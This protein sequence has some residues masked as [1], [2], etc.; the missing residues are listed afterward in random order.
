MPSR[1]RTITFDSHDPLSQA[2]F[3]GEVMGRPVGHDEEEAWVD[4]T[5]DQD[6]EV[7]DLLF[8]PVPESK[9]VKNRVHLDLEPS[10]PREEEVE[11][12]LA[13]GATME[14]DRRNPDGTGWAVLLDP[15]GNEFCVLRSAAERKAT[16]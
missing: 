13:L 3:W 6:S 16:S 9:T 2:R 14:A 4:V 8:Q 12:I 10:I 15:E 5:D 11:R 7:P 1:V